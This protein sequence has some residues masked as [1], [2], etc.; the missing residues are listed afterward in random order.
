MR[1][2][3]L[4]LFVIVFLLFF[5][6]VG[7]G[8]EFEVEVMEFVVFEFM[9]FEVFVDGFMF[10]Y[11]SQICVVGVVVVIVVNDEMLFFK[12]YGDVCFDLQMLVDFE[13]IFFCIGLILKIFVWM[14]V[15]QQFEVGMI[16]L[17]IDVNEY[18][19]DYQVFVMYV[20]IV[21]FGYFLIYS[22]GFEENFIGFFVFE[23]DFW[24]FIEILIQEMLVWVCLLG[25]FLVY[26]N[27]GLVFVML[28]FEDVV[29]W[30]WFEIF[31]QDIFELFGFV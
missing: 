23:F 4:S 17:K 27:Y 7:Q 3:F 31:E 28:V 24:S 19:D 5:L 10:G 16:D 13:Y 6:I 1:S 8:Q 22:V 9:D 18:F 26:F 15:M 29:G 30:L 20:E 21:I 25:M 12:G 14:V 11:C 2:Y